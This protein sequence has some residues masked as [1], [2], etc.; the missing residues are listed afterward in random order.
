MKT[1][2]STRYHVTY[3]GMGG[4]FSEDGWSGYNERWAAKNKGE[5]KEEVYGFNEA[6]AHIEELKTHVYMGK[7]AYPNVQWQIKT[8]T[9]VVTTIN[10]I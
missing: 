5:L 10:Q 4:Y 8:E 1:E 9:S 2:T 3:L 6:L 7:L